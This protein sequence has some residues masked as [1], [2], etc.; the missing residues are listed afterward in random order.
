[1]YHKKHTYSSHIK[2]VTTLSNAYETVEPI[3]F[4]SEVDCREHLAASG[5]DVVWP[6]N[7]GVASATGYCAP[8]CFC[9]VY[10]EHIVRRIKRFDLLGAFVL[11]LHG[12]E[13]MRRG[14]AEHAL[15]GSSSPVEGRH[16]VPDGYRFAAL[17]AFIESFR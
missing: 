14:V 17:K 11:A 6:D 8:D 13:R 16:D 2:T 7:A 9:E 5:L 3:R 12:F 4:L 15:M 1:M 10:R